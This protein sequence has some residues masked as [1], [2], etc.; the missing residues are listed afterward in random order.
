MKSLHLVHFIAA[1]LI[2]ITC[3]QA[4]PVENKN[5]STGA[6]PLPPKAGFVDAATYGFAP[7]A[8]GTVNAQALQRALDQTGT[9]IVSRPGTYA[10]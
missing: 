6:T 1:A 10:L 2:A 4:Q 7:E 3:T 9:I 8:S 5:P